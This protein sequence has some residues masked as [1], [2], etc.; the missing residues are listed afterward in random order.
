MQI[1]FPVLMPLISCCSSPPPFPYTSPPPLLGAKM[2]AQLGLFEDSFLD[3][4][5]KDGKVGEG[6][7][8]GEKIANIFVFWFKMPLV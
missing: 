7:A 4:S 3:V 1:L 5:H 6:G 2:T 8:G